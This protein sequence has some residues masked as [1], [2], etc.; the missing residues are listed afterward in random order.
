KRGTGKKLRHRRR[1]DGLHFGE[2]VLAVVAH[3][4]VGN[5]EL[6]LGIVTEHGAVAHL[7][8]EVKIGHSGG[9]GEVQL[10][11]GSLVIEPPEIEIIPA[12]QAGDK[13]FQQIVPGERLHRLVAHRARH[14]SE[15][16]TSELQSRFDLVC[17]LLL[18]K[19]KSRVRHKYV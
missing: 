1:E 8:D 5:V 11:R 10:S 17:R 3:A 2:E 14:R 16:H 18:E 13:V 12:G 7:P 19:K 9:R 4:A 15:E 6:A